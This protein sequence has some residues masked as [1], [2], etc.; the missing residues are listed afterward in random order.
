MGKHGVLNI[1]RIEHSKRN[2]ASLS[3]GTYPAQMMPPLDARETHRTK[4]RGN[5]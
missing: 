5:S 2:L 4:L 1:G 3:W